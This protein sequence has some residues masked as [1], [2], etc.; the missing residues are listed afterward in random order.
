MDPGDLRERAPQLVSDGVGARRF[1]M[2]PR[3]VGL[4]VDFWV[5][6]DAGE[7]AFKVGGKPLR[8][9][10][11]LDLGDVHGNRIYRIQTRVMRFRDTMV[12]EGAD[13]RR[14][15][16]VR[17]ALVAPLRERWDVEVRGGDNLS[18]RGNVVDHEYQ[19]QQDGHRVAEVSKRWFRVW[20]TYGIEI[21][22][23]ARPE[24]I[25]AVVVAVD[26]MAH[27]T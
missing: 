8:L 24:L 2:R 27:P 1:R 14:V 12:I 18:V 4:G 15:A 16:L 6:D 7:R 17:E 10:N 5:E 3:A 13:G 20:E 11:T 25:L 23:G 21:T 22:P 19:V 9:R 26:A